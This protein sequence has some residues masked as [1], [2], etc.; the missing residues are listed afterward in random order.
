MP[1]PEY[2]GIP[3]REKSQTSCYMILKMLGQW[4]NLKYKDNPFI[5]RYQQSIM[6]IKKYLRR[7]NYRH[8]LVVSEES[9]III[10]RSVRQV[11]Y[12]HLQKRVWTG[13]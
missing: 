8:F 12:T 2:G 9:I 4:N 5:E 7:A 10:H 11:Y 3:W 13:H 6:V 1:N